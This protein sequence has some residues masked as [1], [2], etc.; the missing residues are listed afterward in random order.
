MVQN[1]SASCTS[2]TQ[3]RFFDALPVALEKSELHS[4]ATANECVNSERAATLLQGGSLWLKQ[5]PR[6][7]LDDKKRNVFIFSHSSFI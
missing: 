1:W 7:G 5:V 4:N 3:L 2:L 6:L